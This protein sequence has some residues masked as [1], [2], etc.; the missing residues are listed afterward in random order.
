[1]QAGIRA[2]SSAEK[3]LSTM[4]LLPA[5]PPPV[6][7][8]PAEV[9]APQIETQPSQYAAVE[10]RPPAGAQPSLRVP[11]HARRIRRHPQLPG[12]ILRGPIQTSIVPAAN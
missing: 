10:A 6:E 7:K 4:P 8:A 9:K 11:H 2:N 3:A 1:M 5:I 12:G